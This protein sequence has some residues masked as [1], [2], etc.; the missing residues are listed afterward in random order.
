MALAA[1]EASLTTPLA[2]FSVYLNATGST[3]EPYINWANVHYNFSRVE[4]IPSL[5][6]R[7]DPMTVLSLELT[8]WVVVL[9]AFVFF[10]FF[11]FAE[12]ARKRYRL[13]FWFFAKGLGYSPHVEK[14]RS[15]ELQSF[16]L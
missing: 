15:Y 8:R 3:V 5:I 16:G 10:G 6:W 2:C 13:V 1:V 4:Q 12:E 11:G 9:C 14:E 7:S